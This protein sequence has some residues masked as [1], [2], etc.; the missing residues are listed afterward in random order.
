MKIPVKDILYDDKF[1]C[2][3]MTTVAEVKGLA[4]L[5]RKAGLINPVSVRS[6]SDAGITSHPWHL[7][8]GHRRFIAC[9]QVLR[10]TAIECK[11]VE[12]CTDAEAKKV[13]LIENLGRKDL[14]PGQ[15]LNAILAVYGDDPDPV[16]VAAELGMSKLW[17][18]RRLAIRK[19]AD[20]VKSKFYNGLLTA[21]D[22]SLLISCPLDKQMALVS[23]ILN[24]RAEGRSTSSVAA[25]HGR[26]RRPRSR[27]EIQGM[28]TK[29]LELGVEPSGWQA[30]AWAS[31]TLS[32]EELITGN[33]VI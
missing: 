1:N 10:Q 2:R 27:G 16:T 3:G 5:I 29:L 32:D 20:P 26:L 7:I 19:L 33:G 6:A 25:K 28:M 9:T 31:G 22:L 21:F 8:A 4:E 13:N 23:E 14:H 15:E 11:I 24:A 30:L 18:E 12:N 17:V